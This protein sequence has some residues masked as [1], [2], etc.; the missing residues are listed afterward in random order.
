MNPQ[1]VLFLLLIT[2]VDRIYSEQIIVHV[3]PHSHDDAG[4][5]WTFDEYFYGNNTSKCVKCILDG[6]LESLL[7]DPRRT[8]VEVEIAFFSKWYLALSEEKKNLVKNLVESGR[9]EFA[10][11]GWVMHD[12]AT[13]YYQ[14]FVDNMRL[15]LQFI[16]KEFNKSVETAWFIDPFGHSS[17]NVY[18]TLM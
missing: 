1:I 17:S 11:A 9:W 16:Q 2:A 3:I 8:F 10:N 13:T 5:L 6:T 18:N 4:W 7:S 15:G 12:E 14:H